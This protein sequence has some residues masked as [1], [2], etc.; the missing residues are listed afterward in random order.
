MTD[1]RRGAEAVEQLEQGA[2]NQ[3]RAASR[4]VSARSTAWLHLLAAY[5][6][7]ALAAFL[8]RLLDLG[9]FV[10]L[11]EITFWFGRSEQFLGALQA[12]RYA[13]TAITS[14]PGVTT[15]WTGAAGIWLHD[16]LFAWGLVSDVPFP[17]RLALLRL[18]AALIHAAGVV[19]G[20]ALLRRLLP[21]AVAL[22][23]ALLWAADPFVIAFSQLLHVDGLM[24]T[25]TTLSILA[26]LVFWQAERPP[27][28]Y[29]L[30]SAVCG[31]LA[32]LSKSPGLIVLPVVALGFLGSWVAGS[33]YRV[34]GSGYRISGSGYALLWGAA[35][36]LTCALVWP[37]VWA[38]PLRVYELLRFGVEA[39]GA[40]PHMQGNFFLGRV[41][42]APGPLFYPVV[43]ALRLTPWAML[44]LLLLPLA[45]WCIRRQGDTRARHSLLLLL[46]FVLLFV[47]AMSFF[48]KKFNRYLVPIFPALDILA[49]AG[50]VWGAAALAQWARR[51]TQAV[52]GVVVGGVALLAL[53]HAAWWHPYGVAYFNPLLGGAQAGAETF[54]IGWGEGIEQVADW[55]NQ[56]PDIEG[57]R[58]ATTL[59]K[60]L[61]PYLR[62]GGQVFTPAGERL[63]ANVGYV[64]VYVR[65]PQ[66]TMLGP[67]FDQFYPEQTPLHTVTIHGV[68]YAWIYQVPPPIAQRLSVPF[69]GGALRLTGYAL[70]QEDL[71][72][73]GQLMLTVQW[74]ARQPLAANYLLFVHLLDAQGQRITQADVSP[75]GPDAPTSL[76][77][78]G[79]YYSWAHP[80]PVP[81][82]LPP[83]NYWLALGLYDP[84]SG[85]RLPLAAPMPPDA[86]PGAGDDALL[87]PLRLE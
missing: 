25:F 78:P 75:A 56:Q 20:Y 38:D 83:G 42:D 86:P 34:A 2:I 45:W 28:G 51:G 9:R 48:P 81:A 59:R 87:L 12:G 85:A 60:P 52:T 21:G 61:Q 22:L 68:D 31:G 40:E 11:D 33:G 54:V 30:L 1:M 32:V 13:D 41:L 62:D 7:V 18:P 5:L 74:Q 82:D 80:L 69:D 43:L 64:V 70:A 37:A 3:E 67:P 14:H 36:A 15:M 79:R 35:F 46:A 4:V 26:A 23:A 49:A 6:L 66:R 55:L 47:L 71:R 63:A 24:M 50:L 58:V 73:T 39:E 65:H 77:Q 57:V 53:L 72:A 76:W 17:L 8:P 84:A 16:K 27:L 29:L 19:L 44:G 10:T